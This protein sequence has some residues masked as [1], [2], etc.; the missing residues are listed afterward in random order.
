MTTPLQALMEALTKAGIAFDAKKLD[1]DRDY[2]ENMQ[3]ALDGLKRWDDEAIIGVSKPQSLRGSVEVILPNPPQIPGGKFKVVHLSPKQTWDLVDALIEAARGRLICPRC[4]QTNGQN[5]N[6]CALCNPTRLGDRLHAA[7]EENAKLKDQVRLC[8]ARLAENE[9]RIQFIEKKLVELRPPESLN[10]SLGRIA[11][12]A[13]KLL[14]AEATVKRAFAED[15]ERIAAETTIGELE[16]QVQG[17][18]ADL[19][20]KKELLDLMIGEQSSPTIHCGQCGAS[21][22][23]HS[24][25]RAL[26]QEQEIAKLREGRTRYWPN[27]T[28]WTCRP[29]DCGAGSIIGKLQDELAAPI[30]IRLACE[31]CGKL[32]VDHGDF[33]TKPHHTHACQFCGLPWRPTIRP[34]VGVQFLPGFKDEQH[35]NAHEKAWPGCEACEVL[36][37]G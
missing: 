13:E 9:T 25:T 19:Q 35:C 20:E 7:H 28:T 32:H 11:D 1:S 15:R 16:S 12:V 36:N 34:T 27:G 23:T 21:V 29:N 6:G 2:Y 30:P 14:D 8:E 22:C 24:S 3:A 26:Q 4:K 5:P 31:G 37:K 33:A 10:T 18:R 17:L